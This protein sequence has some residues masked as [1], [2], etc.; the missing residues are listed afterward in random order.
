MKDIKIPIISGLS[1][2]ATLALMPMQALADNAIATVTGGGSDGV[3]HTPGDGYYSGGYEGTGNGGGSKNHIVTITGSAS[4]TDMSGYSI[5]GGGMGN[6]NITPTTSADR[7]QI[8]I[9]NRA[10]V[11]TVIGGEGIGATGNTVN[12]INA[13]VNR[14]V[15]GG[16]GTWAG[17]RP[18]SGNAV[19]N[20]VNIEGN[21]HIIGDNKTMGYFQAIVS[22]GRA[23]Y[24]HSAENNT[25]NIKSAA[26]IDKYR[27]EGATIHEG[28]SA[29]G[30]SVNI[31]G[32]IVLNSG[33]EIDG[34]VSVSPNFVS[35]LEENYVVIN[36]AG[37][38]L[39]NI[40]GAN[41]TRE[42]ITIGSNATAI[43]NWVELKAG[44]VESTTGS[45][46]AAVS[47]N[48]YS[49]ITGGTVIRDVQGGFGGGGN[50]THVAT[51]EGDYANISGG[52]IG[53]SAYGFRN[54]NG[55][56]KSSYVEM[57]G[58]KVAQD[59]IGGNSVNGKISNTK[60]TLNGGEVSHDVIGGNSVNGE[61]TGARVDIK[62]G[63]TIGHDI[64]G[65]R[66]E[67][68]KVE[69]S[70]V[71]ADLTNK[72]VNQVIGGTNKIGIGSGTANNNHVQVT[73]GTLNGAA[74]GGRG[75][76]GVSGNEFSATGVTFNDNVSGGTT[77]KGNATG[78]VLTLSNSKVEGGKQVKGGNAMLLGSASGNRVNLWD[79]TTVTGD[80]FGAEA[81]GAN[82]DNNTVHLS[83]STVTGTI[84]GLYGTGSGSGNTLIN[85]SN[86]S[87]PNQAGNIARFNVLNFQNISNAYSDASKAALQITDGVKTNINKAKFQLGDHDYDVDTYAIGDGEK[88]YLIHNEAKF[89]KFDEKVK[90]TDNVFT[91]KN[92]TTYS[93]NLKGLMEDDDGKSI[94]IQGKKK[95]NRTIT[96]GTFD[97]SE[98]NKYKGPAGEDPTIDVGEDPN[99]PENFGGLN[100]DTN[101][102]PKATINLVSG[103]NIGTIKANDDDTINVGKDGNNP[104]VPGNITAKNIEKSGPGKLKINFNLPNNYNGGN[105]AIKLTDSGTTDLTGTDVNVNNAKDGT[106][107]TLVKKT[108]GGTINFND[109]DVQKNQTYT[110]TDKDHYQYD[111]ET[112]RREN[113]NQELVYKKGTITNAWGDTDFDSSELT[114]NQAS[115]KAAGATELFGNKGN[116]VIVKEGTGNLGNK[117]I[118][119][120]RA[121][122]KDTET[123]NTIHN[124]YTTI[125]GGTGFGDVYAGYGDSGTQDV[126]DNHLNFEET[127]KGAVVNGNIG[128]GYNANGNVHDNKVTTDDTT[129]NGNVYGAQTANGNAV[130]NIVNLQ[131]SRVGGDVY[132]SKA[133]GSATNSTVNL[134]NTQVAGNVYA[135]DAASGSGNTVNFYGGKVGKT[136]YGLSSAGGTNNTL[137]VYNASTQKTAGDIANLNVLNF[138]GISSA[139]GSAA[140][141][142]LN[143]TTT[144]DTNIINDAKFKLNGEEYDVNKDTYH[145]LNIEE[146][147][148]YYL[149]H[150]AGNTFT[151][152]KEKAK[153]T[154]NEFTITGKSSYEINLKGLI[155]SADNQSILVQG[156]RLTGRNISSDGKFDNEEI[157]KY[158]PDLSNGANIN[159]GKTPG[160]NKDFE[161]LD[162]D[163]SN[164]PGVK[165]KVTLVDGKNIGT[166]K[167]DADDTINV[168]KEDGSLVPGTIE[169]KNIVGV[170][171]L[172]FNM[173]NGYNGDPALKLTGNTSTN[174]I[175]TDVKIN[176]A[177][178]DKDYTL[179]KGNADIN[180]QDK[181]TQKEQVYNII[182]NAH[183]QYD[184]ETFRKQNNNKELIYREGTITDAW[185]DNDFDSNELTKNKADN[186]HQGGTPLFDNKGNTV[187]IVSTA[188]DLST[189][190]VYG[191]ATLSGSTDDVFNNTVNINGADTK[192]IFAGASKGSGRVYD[193]VVNFNAGS[194]VNAISGSDDASNARGNNSGNTL[195]VNNAS[196]Q[197]TAGDIKNFNALNFDGISD[198]NGNAA[199]AALNLTTNADTDI[200]DAKFKLGG[201]EYNVDKDTYGSLNIEEG[202]EYHLIRNTGNTFTSFTE[203]AKQTTNE[204]TLKNS[205]TYDIM[206]KG[207]IKSS[208]DQSI[209]I[210]G[211]K[212]T[213]RNIT[214]GEFGNDEI[215]R[216]NPIPN[217]IINVVNENPNN[218]TNFN[219]LNIDGGNNSTVNLTGG[220]NIGD[221]TGGAG[222]TLNV[223]KDTTN[224]AAPNSITAKNIGGF[225]D[226]NIFMPPTVKDG[227]SMIKL[228]DP[229]AN[230][231]LSNMRGKITAY[232]SGNTDVGDTSTIHLIDKQGSGQLLLPDPSHLQTRVQQ[233][234]TI[235][236]ETYGMV[237][238]N[239]RALDLRF[240]GKRRVKE[241]TKSFAETRAAS[242]ASLKSGSELITNYLDK[243][244]PDGHLELFPFAISEAYSLRYETGSHVNSKGYGVAAGLASLTENFA[245]DILSGVFVEYG[246]AN[247]DSYLDSGLHA[248]GDSEY[249]GGGLMLKQNFTSGTYLDASFHVGKISSDYNSNDWTYA[250]AP[251]VLA[252][253]EK[254][255]ISSTYIATHI[256]IG[257]IF[258]LSQS[259][260]LD[261]Y[262]KWLYAYTD[263]ADATISSGERYHF[264][265]VTSNRLRAGLRDTINLKD[266]HNLYFGG[267]YE[268]EFSGDAKAS[269]MGLDAPKPSLKGSTGVF[270]AGYK[271]ESKN[272]ILSLGGKGYIGKTRGGAINAGFE[273][274]F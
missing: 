185:N 211:N 239:G 196:T 40:T 133:S 179:I 123:P 250:I 52:E 230:T 75:E 227:D 117:N 35:T 127:S 266:E 113:G 53:G 95:T 94:V 243:L 50:T 194:V 274:M 33:Q 12:I 151:G 128:A 218:P 219:G 257:Q 51:S 158:T 149:I 156:K 22:G 246:K 244:I 57:S 4:G 38:K 226:I 216:Y 153:Q 20:T 26:Q 86:A 198:A 174:L 126:H 147:K 256:G 77:S 207:L 235:E 201:E 98:F 64:I 108:N 100:I 8:T 142:A 102:I 150:N 143:L 141:A 271:Y 186:A 122:V 90:H 46:M 215:N 5:Y 45:Y 170:G 89:E 82:S 154:D 193:N 252:H 2:A 273:I 241:D 129:I 233:G 144:N 134:S 91:I 152:F 27:I 112:F 189:K 195:N 146:G 166:I 260:K 31:T 251:G 87:N 73:G 183:Y 6:S 171:K 49:K 96:D 242:L 70:W 116:T 264:D 255:D 37:A 161:G 136:I 202:K 67:E 25:V 225:D 120:G 210:Q 184:G 177:Q 162:I 228:T 13:T 41:A 10:T 48:N 203:K 263:D 145:S 65:G 17:M 155:Q 175:G 199:T 43:G 62:K 54:V 224:P 72:T 16:N 221:I 71:V 3:L 23:R 232:V 205:T 56:I 103:D 159:V 229:T 181:T 85:A 58:G 105:P 217:P 206:L 148:E 118:S 262:T 163:T 66:S 74:L 212:L 29:K 209:L 132:G 204:F 83:D 121:D 84:Y 115:N 55:E 236:Y 21:S 139:N 200:N 176:N 220:N 253:N 223:G 24:G 109:R 231:D 131:G 270:E 39:Q 268:Y 135:A 34:A 104:L 63:A 101:A 214:G 1:I 11:T 30:N 19:G 107:Y 190:S 248:D 92:A 168:G 254:F 14:V 167:G 197:K 269:T 173:P 267:A 182:D 114:K 164:T 258:D 261:V 36:S 237:D 272:L 68:G 172:N 47:K 124:N 160:T 234:A 178:K 265:S 18:Q 81:V 157:T 60:V 240:S 191:G 249:I 208:D 97:Q 106:T 169:A 78:N 180:F 247:Y 32:A 111:G 28:G 165:S 245:G 138:D 130:K 99:A 9:Q 259:N 188:G 213:S 7:N 44:Q 79:H 80:V 140:T 238:A 76:Q 93:M 125:K 187:N 119:S 61:V 137:N 59:A 192:E 110:I 15:L 69:G 88:R 222:S 42:G